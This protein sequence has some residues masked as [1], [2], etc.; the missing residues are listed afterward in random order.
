MMAVLFEGCKSIVCN[1]LSSGW[2]YLVHLQPYQQ[3][4]SSMG[5]SCQLL[6][7]G[8]AAGCQACR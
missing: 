6:S 7:A 4:C 5:S 8:L 2:P 1:G 3:A